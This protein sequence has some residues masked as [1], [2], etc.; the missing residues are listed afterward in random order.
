MILLHWEAE[1]CENVSSGDRNLDLD[2]GSS[3]SC[4]LWVNCLTSL[5]FSCVS[6]RIIVRT[7][8]KWIH[9]KQLGRCLVQS[10]ESSTTIANQYSGLHF[11]FSWLKNLVLF[12]YFWLGKIRIPF[13]FYFFLY[14]SPSS[15]Y[16]IISLIWYPLL[17]SFVLVSI[18]FTSSFVMLSIGPTI[19]W[20]S[21]L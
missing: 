3:T 4:V 20:F 12:T 5:S 14:L 10:G 18:L 9:T 6:Y 17:G 19:S 13:I 21:A 16:I 1:W 11:S 2:S 7:Q 15:V 8:R